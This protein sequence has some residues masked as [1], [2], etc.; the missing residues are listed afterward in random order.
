[1]TTTPLPERATPESLG[2][3]STGLARLSSA[4]GEMI[5][6]KRLPGAVAMIVRRGRL[7]YFE[8]LGQRDPA[9]ADA[10]QRDAIFRV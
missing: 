10:M 4:L 7:A 5:D 8:A 9:Q 2:F 3:T 1:M 6:Q